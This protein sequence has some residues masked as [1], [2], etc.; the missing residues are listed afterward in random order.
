MWAA[1][2]IRSRPNAVLRQSDRRA[3]HDVRQVGIDPGHIALNEGRMVRALARERLD[4]IADAIRKLGQDLVRFLS[5]RRPIHASLR[6]NPVAQ[7]MDIG[8]G[9]ISTLASNLVTL[10]VRPL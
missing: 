3:G 8:N 4:D 6:F 5:H 10:F 7:T 2:A 1:C 9:V